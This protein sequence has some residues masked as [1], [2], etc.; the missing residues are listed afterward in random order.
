M[1][2]SVLVRYCP[3]VYMIWEFFSHTAIPRRP[4]S[5]L[6]LWMW[7]FCGELLLRWFPKI[8]ACL[9]YQSNSCWVN[10]VCKCSSITLLQQCLVIYNMAVLIIYIATPWYSIGSQIWTP[11]RPLLPF[12]TIQLPT[13]DFWTCYDL[14]IYVKMFPRSSSIQLLTHV[15][16]EEIT[17]F[18]IIKNS[19]K[20]IMVCSSS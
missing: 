20:V 18:V 10:C 19:K 15:K 12:R 7:Y 9:D 6:F 1:M 2:E 8:F 14:L 3:K 16:Y 13:V 4:I 11:E 5:F 17:N